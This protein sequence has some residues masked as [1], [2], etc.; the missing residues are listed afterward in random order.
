MNVTEKWFNIGFWPI[1]Y[2]IW[3]FHRI[4]KRWTDEGEKTLASVSASI[5]L[6]LLLQQMQRIP[7]SL[8]TNK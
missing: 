8:T 2:I 1:V 4:Q 7:K 3:D 6:I 5:E